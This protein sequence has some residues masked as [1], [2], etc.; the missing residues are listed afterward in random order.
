MEPRRRFAVGTAALAGAALAHGALDWGVAGTLTFAAVAVAAAFVAEAVV[1]AAALLRH[2]TAPRL[3]GVPVWALAGWVGATYWSYRL[4]A[5]VVPVALAPVA[6]GV[7][8]TAVDLYGDP[9]GVE[10]GLWSY[11]PARVSR[12]R[13]RAVPWWNFAGWFALT[14][15][16]TW[17][18]TP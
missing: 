16:V 1:V 17:L 14:V 7:L 12:P 5:L 9:V 6:A 18:A 3:A 11:P 8:A 2:H 15:S 10:D 13:Y 4:A